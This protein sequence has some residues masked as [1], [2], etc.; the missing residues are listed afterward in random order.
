M[1]KWW[2]GRHAAFRALSAQAGGGS[3]PLFGTSSDQDLHLRK[4]LILL[5]YSSD[6]P[7]KIALQ[8]WFKKE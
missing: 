6:L 1:P 7:L 8:F 4:I 3:S 2:N 5:K